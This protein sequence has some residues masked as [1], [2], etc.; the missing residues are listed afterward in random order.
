MSSRPKFSPR[1]SYHW[2]V[3]LRPRSRMLDSA[4]SSRSRYSSSFDG[5]FESMSL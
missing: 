2:P 5:S 1:K 4:P 3:V